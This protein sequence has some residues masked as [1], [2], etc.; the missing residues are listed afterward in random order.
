MEHIDTLV[1]GAGVIG[2]AIA[3]RLSES[4]NIAVIEQE[5]HFGEHS[6]S[7]NSEVI[8]AGLYYNT[9]SL[10][11][12]LCV[13]GKKLLYDHCEQYRVP[14]QRTGKLLVA[15]TEQED[16]KLENIKQQAQTNGVRDL[17]FVTATQL[18][19]KVPY[20]NAINGLWSPSTG[21]IDSH[22]YLL[23]LLH[24][25]EQNRSHYVPKTKFTR[26]TP[27]HQGFEVTLTIDGSPY[28]LTCSNLINAGGLFASTNAKLIEGMNK[29]FIPE[30]LYC[31]GQ[32]FRYHGKH[33]FKNLIYPVPEQHGLGI[34]ATI[35]MAGQLK[36]GPD[37]QFID[38]LDYATDES[39]KGK[40]VQAIKRYW[41]TLDEK[42]LHMDYTGIR[43]KLQKNGLQDFIVQ[44]KET[45]GIAGLVNLFGI[46][47]P[48]LTASLALAEYIDEELSTHRN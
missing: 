21:I 38:Q 28:Q 8:H 13:R 46:E 5:N 20:L 44:G 34:H 12:K 14:F 39:V 47:S 40:F 1:I 35:D 16:Q 9:D 27:N 24:I 10:K 18:S 48:G 30:T 22:Q 25:I 23:S 7:R 43:P 6:S 36:F 15:Q 31:R 26:A 3:A 42:R 32:Y 2:L 45:H 41:P 17:A 29:K 11:A 37:T 19:Q 4:Q 33:P